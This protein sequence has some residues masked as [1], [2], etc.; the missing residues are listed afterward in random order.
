MEQHQRA[1]MLRAELLRRTDLDQTARNARDPD[2]MARVDGDNLPW[3]R[4]VIAETGWPARSAVGEDGAA[5]AWL[6]AQHAD[7]DPAFQRRCLSLLTAA[8]AAGEASTAHLAYLTDRVLLAEGQPQEFGTQV[9]GRNGN[10]FPRRLRDPGQ[11]DER[12]AAMSLGPL[13]EYLAGF[14]EE[15]TPSATTRCPA[16]CGLVEFWPPEPGERVSADCAD[17]GRTLTLSVE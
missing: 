10:W 4:R 11:V 14:A 13:A 1:A 17:C 7:E 6:L 12:R 3:F 9:T 15:G 2:A 16:C 8:A 5:A